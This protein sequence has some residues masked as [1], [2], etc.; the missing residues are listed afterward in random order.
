MNESVAEHSHSASS[1]SVQGYYGATHSA[2]TTAAQVGIQNNEVRWAVYVSGY[3]P[4]LTY[5]MVYKNSSGQVFVQR[6]NSNV[7]MDAV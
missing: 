6:N 7:L 1:A 4:I 3:P 5:A 2:A